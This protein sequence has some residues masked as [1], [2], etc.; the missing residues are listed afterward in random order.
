MSQMRRKSNF[1]FCV[2][3][4][5]KDLPC[6]DYTM[7]WPVLPAALYVVRLCLWNGKATMTC[8][9]VCSL[10]HAHGGTNYCCFCCCWGLPSR[11][12]AGRW[13]LPAW[14]VGAGV[15][16]RVLMSVITCLFGISWD[17]SSPNTL[18][19]GVFFKSM[20]CMLIGGWVCVGTVGAGWA[21]P[22]VGKAF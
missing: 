20:V 21:A 12:C 19:G 4:I 11:E 5:M 14:E 15:L 10:P 17:G 6:F 18:G 1:S 2:N 22:D 9:H 13:P 16:Q 3:H 7:G 8:V